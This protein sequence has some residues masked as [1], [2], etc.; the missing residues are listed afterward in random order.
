MTELDLVSNTQQHYELW[1]LSWLGDISL[2]ENCQL[3]LSND[4]I[5]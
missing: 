4:W 3:L 1:Q 2:V 5:R